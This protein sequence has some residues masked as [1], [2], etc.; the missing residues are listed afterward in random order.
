[1]NWVGLQTG[2]EGMWNAWGVR[3]WW[4]EEGGGRGDV[5]MA[6]PVILSFLDFHSPLLMAEGV[7]TCEM[8]V[9]EQIPRKGDT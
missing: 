3:T 2:K 1:M 4:G 6:K 8:P 5:G 9:L 7:G